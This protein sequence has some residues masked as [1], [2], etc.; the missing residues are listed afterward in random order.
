[1]SKRLATNASN[2]FQFL[3]MGYTLREIFFR[4]FSMK[5]HSIFISRIKFP[6]KSRG[7]NV[8]IDPNVQI[9]GC[10]FISVG[11]NTWLQRRSWLAVPLVDIATPENK[12]YLKV[13]KGCRVGPGSTISSCNS[14]E[15]KDNVLLGP[16]VLIIDHG[17]GYD[18]IT[19]PILDQGLCPVGSVV[20]GENS[21]LGANCVIYAGKSIRI[22][23]NSVVAANSV[24]REDVPDYTVVSGNPAVVVRKYDLNI[25]KWVRPDKN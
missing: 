6:L 24:V 3:K 21:W 11:D 4:G 14:I 13:G 8:Q 1:M 2:I 19:K 22:G 9:D 15:I 18:E 16:N 5:I 7:N 20:I 12:I 25:Q 17:H 10:Q 23:R